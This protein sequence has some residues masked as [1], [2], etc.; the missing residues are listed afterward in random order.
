MV[1][2][3]LVGC[4]FGK[5]MT[6]DQFNE[7]QKVIADQSLKK[8]MT[9]DEVRALIGDPQE[10]LT[11]L[12]RPNTDSWTYTSH[13]VGLRYLPIGGGFMG[14]WVL[15]FERK[16]LVRAVAFQSG[17]FKVKNLLEGR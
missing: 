7:T 1:L 5:P 12:L 13:S 2:G 6:R 16:K 10:T 17:G 3:F 11:P 15:T 9:E 4:S 14:K 8:G